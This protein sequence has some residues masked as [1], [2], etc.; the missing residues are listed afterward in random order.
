MEPLAYSHELPAYVDPA[1]ANDRPGVSS[2]LASLLV[3]ASP[4]ALTA[5]VAIGLA[6]HRLVT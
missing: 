4:F 3:I 2:G 5:W 6:V 1:E